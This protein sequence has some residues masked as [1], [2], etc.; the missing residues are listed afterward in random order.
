M[1]LRVISSTGPATYVLEARYERMRYRSADHARQRGQP[2]LGVSSGLVADERPVEPLDEA[3]KWFVVGQ[4]S[5]D[6]RIE[7]QRVGRTAMLHRMIDDQLQ[8]QLPGFGGT[9]QCFGGL[10]CVFERASSI[11]A[12]AMMISSL[13]LNW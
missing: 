3:L 10:E 7:L 12:T 8:Q 1:I 2:D 5:N 6:Y 11:S 4:H 9:V 13:V